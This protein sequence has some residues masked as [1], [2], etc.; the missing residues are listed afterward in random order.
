MTSLMLQ[1]F[2]IL[3]VAFLIGLPLGDLLARQV[4]RWLKRP[5]TETERMLA[6]IALTPQEAAP[7]LP[8]SP[9]IYP[10]SAFGHTTVSMPIRRDAGMGT[11]C[12]PS[13]PFISPSLRPP[14][15]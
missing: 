9:L 11:A 7:P 10:V 5:R 3:L 12:P 6:M 13:D 15:R 14:A 2:L 8:P 1:G 4:R